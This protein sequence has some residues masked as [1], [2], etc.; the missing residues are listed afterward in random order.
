MNSLCLA[1][2]FVTRQMSV[3]SFIV[4]L[5][6]LVRLYKS[7]NEFFMFG[8]DFRYAPN[9]RLFIYCFSYGLDHIFLV[10]LCISSFLVFCNYF[11][12]APNER[13]LFY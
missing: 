5:F 3:H 12:D 6:V 4:F 10:S 13:F 2:I 7:T 11:Q 9:A 1:M 8:N